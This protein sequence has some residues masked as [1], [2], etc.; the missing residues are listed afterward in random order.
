M[1][2]TLRI[3]NPIFFTGQT[4]QVT[5]KVI[6]CHDVDTLPNGQ[7]KADG[8]D[9]HWDGILEKLN[10]AGI[11]ATCGLLNQGSYERIA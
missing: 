1:N 5:D 6:L 11:G 4:Q 10:G 7:P 3:T 8:A 9:Y 2:I